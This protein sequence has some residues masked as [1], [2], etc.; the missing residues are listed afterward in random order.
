MCGVVQ[1]QT[2]YKF[3]SAILE[4][5]RDGKASLPWHSDLEKEL[6]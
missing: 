2:G 3:N 6:G 5:F 1:K 4:Y